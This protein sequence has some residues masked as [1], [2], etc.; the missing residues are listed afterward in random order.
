MEKK[1]IITYVQYLFR[2]I[3][4]ALLVFAGILKMQ[5]NS[6]LFESVA[7]ITWIPIGIKSLVIDLLPYI[8]IIV[9]GLLAFSLFSK[10]VDPI[11][12]GIYL[13]FFIFAIYGLGQGIE[14]DC[15]C[16][17]ELG[18]SSLIGALLGSEFGWKMVIRNGIFLLM[19]GFLF[20]KPAEEK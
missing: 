11:A 5:D 16:F 18:E 9:G 10:V 17:G 12:T 7:Y 19:A 6:A 15:G 8:E 2:F 13:V 3:L 14:G 4:G 1:R 20:W